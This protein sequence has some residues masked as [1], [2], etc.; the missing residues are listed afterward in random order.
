LQQ[1][2]MA[3]SRP[4]KGLTVLQLAQA[5]QADPLQVEPVMESLCGLDWVGLL[6]ESLEGGAA[7]YILL[8]DPDATPLQPLLQALLLPQADAPQYRWQDRLLSPLCLR[9]VL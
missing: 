8:A 7:R 1:L 5:L 4:D 9:D 6:D 3:R 2:A